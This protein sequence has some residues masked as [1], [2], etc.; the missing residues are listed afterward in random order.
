LLRHAGCE[1][2]DLIGL[3][4]REGVEDALGR[5]YAAGVFLTSAETKGLRPVTRGTTSFP[6]DLEQLR[7][8]G[9]TAL[10]PASQRR[11]LRHRAIFADLAV[12]ATL[13][14]EARGGAGWLLGQWFMSVVWLLRY[15][16]SGYTLARWFVRHDPEAAPPRQEERLAMLSRLVSVCARRPFPRPEFVP[17][18]DAAPIVTWMRETLRA[19][20]TPHLAAATS[21]AVEVCETARRLSVDLAG[22]EFGVSSDPLTAARLSAIRRSGARAVPSYGANEAGLMA[23]GCLRPAWPDDMHVYDDVHA[24]IQPGAAGATAGLPAGA[25][26]V[27]SLR[28][29]TPYVLLN[30]SL[31]DEA[32]LER[33][34]CGCALEAVGWSTHVHTVRSFEKMKLGGTGLFVETIVRL[35]EDTLPAR[36]GGGATDYQLVEDEGVIVD[37][38][39]RLRLLIH[40]RVGAVPVDAVAEAFLAMVRAAGLPIERLWRDPRWLVIERRPPYESTHGKIYH[41]HRSSPS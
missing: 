39:Q 13:A 17:L 11:V 27:S 2:G 25:L 22:A 33:R 23:Y 28:A 10:H 4:R 40:P 37:G 5:L 31:G 15:Q 3:V 38:T 30:V 24:M 12:N 26:L 16:G 36:F 8:P 41:V 20:R 18:A 6:L 34:A 1:L 7:N 21:S 32:V 9:W 14:L 29:S 19:G 35:L